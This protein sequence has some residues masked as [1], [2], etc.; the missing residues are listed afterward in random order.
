MAMPTEP[1]IMTFTGGINNRHTPL[2]LFTRKQSEVVNLVNADTTLLGRIKLLLP[3][4]A[5]NSTPVSSI[6]SIIRAN[7]WVFVGASTTLYYCNA[8]AVLIPII[9]GLSGNPIC[10]AHAGNWVYLMDGTYKKSVYIGGATPTACDW[11]QAVP[12]APPTVADSTEAGN[13]DGTYSCYYRY[14]IT[15][16]DASIIFTGLSPVGSVTVVT[17]KIAWSDLVH[18]TFAGATTKQIEL[19]RTKAGWAG[20]YLIATIDE[21]TTTYS[22]DVDDTPAQAST[23]FEEDGYYPPP[24]GDLC[25]YH[26][27]SDRTW[28]AD[29]N[30][31]YWSEPA[32]YNIFIYDETADEYT[33]VNSVFLDGENITSMLVFDEQVYFA[34][35]KTWRRLRGTNPDYWTFEDISLCIKGPA[36]FRLPVTTNWGV[37]YPGNDKYFWLFNGF[38]TN[39]IIDHFVFSTTPSTEGHATYDGRFIR[40][41]YEDATYPLLI[42]DFLGF[43]GRAPRVIQSTQDMTAS[44]YDKAENALYYGDASGYLRYGQDTSTEVTMTVTLGEIPIDR[45]INLGEMSSLLIQANTD[46]ENLAITPVQDG[47]SQ[48]PLANVNTT[49]LQR[50]VLPLPLNQYRALSFTL[51]ITGAG[52]DI[53]LREPWLLRKEDDEDDAS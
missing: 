19:Y 17:N 2:E 40:L 47:E 7:D 50:E 14:K 34:S 22:D 27:G 32:M 10:F 1:I 23:E 48:T 31:A 41:F 44:F 24:A 30:N 37:I 4:S 38:E 51:S 8:S 43:P 53:E 42:I 11:G 18:S 20:T 9:P 35:K 33:N 3:L 13:P 12:T 52:T 29:G 28:V 6:H 16:P 46:G 25:L 21:G 26:P 45:L 15:L 49:S 39:R 5:L 36:H